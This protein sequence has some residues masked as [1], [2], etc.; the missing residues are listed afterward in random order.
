MDAR[1]EEELVTR[2]PACG[3]E[4]AWSNR[5]G[6]W[7]HDDIWASVFCGVDENGIITGSCVIGPRRSAPGR[8]FSGDP[9]LR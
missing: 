4:I 6:G 2:C 9:H 8:R 3:R 5:A 1:T 7:V